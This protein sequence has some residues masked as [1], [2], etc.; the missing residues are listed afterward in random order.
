MAIAFM[1][2]TSEFLGPH[3]GGP[4]Q[5]LS[6]VV[7]SANPNRDN[8]VP[9]VR[10]GIHPTTERRYA[11]SDGAFDLIANEWSNISASSGKS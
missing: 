2:N 1:L 6:N 10:S 4:R 8:N 7:R 9:F 5:I 11:H 3:G